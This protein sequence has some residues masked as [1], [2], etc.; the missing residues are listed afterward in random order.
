LRHSVYEKQERRLLAG[1]IGQ[2]GEHTGEIGETRNMKRDILIVT[3]ISLGVC[4]AAFGQFPP[5]KGGKGVTL[6]ELA[7]LDAL[8]TVV[9]KNSNAVDKNLRVVEVTPEYISFS[10]ENGERLSYR[11]SDIKEIQIQEG[12]ELVRR[13]KP[14]EGVGLMPAQQQALARAIERA[15][16]LFQNTNDNQ[17][18]KLD[19][20]VLLGVAGEENDKN[21]ART[22]VKELHGAN[23]LGVAM[24]AGYRLYLLGESEAVKK[25]V[26]DE[27]LNSGNREIANNAVTLAGLLQYRNAENIL[28]R[29]LRDRRADVAAA[30]MKALARLGNRDILPAA[31]AS[32]S[33]RNPEKGEAAVFVLSTLGDAQ[34]IDEVKMLLRTAEGTTRFRAARV[35]SALKAPEGDQILRDEIMELPT[36]QI[37]AA[38]VLAKQSDVKAMRILRER[39]LRRYDEIESTLLLRARMAASLIAGG[40]RTAVPALQ[41]LLRS[42]M[43]SV[44]KMVCRLVVELG[45][46]SMVT[47]IQPSLENKDPEVAVAAAQAALASVN[48]EFRKRLV[49]WWQ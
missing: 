48:P 22:Y 26:L 10:A 4:F 27:A 8:V 39:L 37:E 5:L 25:E 30:A 23:D 9:L 38:L 11:C 13:W 20:A 15:K 7:N 32:L 2:L 3:A 35:L 36:L 34:T 44:Q 43:S 24:L 46:R 28:Y 33:E 17:T 29:R 18:V 40:D 21:T 45:N 12:Q 47:I 41:G 31:L 19:A 16:E 6:E 14:A 1:C 49:S 42:E